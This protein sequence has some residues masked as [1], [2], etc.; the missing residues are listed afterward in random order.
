MP[1]KNT[2]KEPFPTDKLALLDF[3]SADGRKDLTLEDAFVETTSVKLFLQDR[4]SII[5]GQMGSGKSALFELLK[6]QSKKLDI[7]RKRLI[8]PI[9][10]AISFHLLRRFIAEEFT[11]HDHKLVF[12]L[13][14]KFQILNNICEE[15]S[16]LP[17]FPD[18]SHEKEL[19]SFLKQ[20]KSR[21]FDE[22]IIGKLK[23]LLKDTALTIKTKITSTP[24]TIE[25]QVSKDKISQKSS[26]VLNLDRLYKCVN[27]SISKRKIN[28]I[29]VIV[30]RIDTF[31]AGEEYDTQK[32]YIE[33]LLEVDDDIDVS[34]PNIGR[35][36]FL[37]SDLFA[38][39]DYE[40]LGYDKVNDN[41]LRIE[42]SDF[43]LVYF[44]ANRILYG[45]K[46]QK[47]LTE[48]KIL[49]STNLD[50]FHFSIERFVLFSFIPLYL[51]KKSAVFSSIHQERDASL[52]ERLNKAIVTKVFPRTLVHKDSTLDEKEIC[53]FDFLLSHFKDGH[54]KVTPR[55]LLAFLKQVVETTSTYYEENPDQEV[56]VNEIDGDW[57]WE[58]FKK[59]CVYEAYCK[60]KSGYIRNLSKVSNEWTPYFAAF[61]GKRG[62]KKTIDYNWM[63]NIINLDEEQVVSFLAYLNHIGFLSILEPHPD[64]KKRKYRIPIIYL[65]NPNTKKV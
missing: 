40:A 2:L 46:K 35:K 45:F 13:I 50:D 3:G 39:L 43:E 9:E 24:I 20:I 38:R 57:E 30:D 15:L 31:V 48:Y 11:G 53:V 16:K 37:R 47:L 7:Y 27:D 41:T 64:P 60:S 63:R 34:Y 59:K 18:S 21:E 49:R 17:N 56:H 36:I 29:L 19:N 6:N 8:V 42:W 26:D 55:N 12:K 14:W 65:S 22:S 54:E 10:E 61:I 23:G 25:A 44:L 1:S 28:K 32:E 5:I 52:L 4:H 62:N 51:K 58:L 33:A